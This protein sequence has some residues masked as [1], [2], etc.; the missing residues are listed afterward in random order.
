VYG[1]VGD[2]SPHVITANKS[3]RMRQAGHVACIGEVINIYDILIEKVN[4]KRSLGRPGN[5]SEDIGM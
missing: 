5:R 4:G 2:V 1:G 3:R